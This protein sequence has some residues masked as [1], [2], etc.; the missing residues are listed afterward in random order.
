MEKYEVTLQSIAK[1]EGINCLADFDIVKSNGKNALEFMQI[2]SK[3]R[4]SLNEGGYFDLLTSDL[5][6]SISYGIKFSILN[7]FFYAPYA[8]NLTQEITTSPTGEKFS[9]HHQTEGDKRFFYYINST[10]EKLYNFWD[11]IGDI[12]ALSFKL[13]IAEQNVYFGTVIAKLKEELLLSESGKWLKNFHENEYSKILNKYRRKIVHY[14]QQDTDHFFE[15]LSIVANQ[16]FDPS[17]IQSLQEAKNQLP[18]TLKHQL[19]LTN[20]GFEMMVNF[21][22]EKGPFEKNS[23]DK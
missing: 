15:W 7:I 2:I 16:Q 23:E 6:R 9:T 11:R 4:E 18:N 5:I 8:N 22:H 1:K 20:E 17:Q 14:K 10:F 12:L 19:E 3:T 21:I 13:D